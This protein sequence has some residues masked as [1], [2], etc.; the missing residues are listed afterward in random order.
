MPIPIG[1]LNILPLFDRPNL[2][3]NWSPSDWAQRNLVE[4]F[5]DIFIPIAQRALN[6]G[7]IPVFPPLEPVEIIG[8]L[9]SYILPSRV[10]NG[11]VNRIYWISLSYQPMPGQATAPRIGVLV[12]QN[13][14]QRPDHI[15]HLKIRKI[16]SVSGFSTG[17]W[18]SL[19]PL[20][21]NACRSSF[22]VL[23][24]GSVTSWIPITCRRRPGPHLAE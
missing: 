17:T 20:S 10:Y 7:L 22:S 1:E 12:D 6:A 19:K 21:E 24:A 13:A 3:K 8:I 4:R 18:Q 14:G 23:A 2:L 9:P 5:L 16:I 15:P 11:G